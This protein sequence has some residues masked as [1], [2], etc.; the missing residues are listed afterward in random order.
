MNMLPTTADSAPTETFPPTGLVVHL[1]PF[2]VHVSSDEPGFAQM[3]NRSYRALPRESS[4]TLAHFRV[5]VHR[6]SRLR[7]PWRP[8][9]RFVF[10]GMHPFEPYPASHA[11]PMFEWGLNWCIATTA[12]QYLLLH[13]ATIARNQRAVLM[14]ALPGSGKSTLAACLVGEGWQLLSDEF[15]IVDPRSGLLL[16]MPRPIPLKN[17][18][19]AVFRER[20]TGLEL[21]PVYAGTRK[22]DVAHVLPPQQSLQQQNAAA[23]P[24]LIIFPKYRASAALTLR[25]QPPHVAHTRLANNAFNYQVRGRQAFD[26]VSH[27]AVSL[28]AYELIFSD[29]DAAMATISDLLEEISA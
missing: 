4:G 9:V 18:S 29:T 27:M 20:G 11:F 1:G 12:H 26:V 13:C 24:A 10:E 2:R 28:P 15:G 23:V 21:G 19:I 3:F 22:G 6:R 25:R 8:Q 17:A 16:P 7:R 14:P 5:G